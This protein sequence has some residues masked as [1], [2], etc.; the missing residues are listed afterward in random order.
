MAKLIPFCCRWNRNNCT[1]YG[2][3]IQNA[4]HFPNYF[5]IRTWELRKLHAFFYWDILPNQIKLSILTC[6]PF[7]RVHGSSVV[8]FSVPFPCTHHPGLNQLDWVVKQDFGRLVKHIFMHFHGS[9]LKHVHQAFRRSCRLHFKGVYCIG[10]LVGLQPSIRSVFL[11]IAICHR[12]CCSR[13]L[14]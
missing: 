5:I 13:F 9:K 2:L 12:H 4:L 3:T 14:C 11:C 10:S 6:F 1:I 8:S 7:P